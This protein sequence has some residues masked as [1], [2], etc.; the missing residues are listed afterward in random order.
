VGT[1]LHFFIEPGENAHQRY[2]NF[3]AAA[4][5]VFPQDLKGMEKH[6]VMVRDMVSGHVGQN[7]AHVRTEGAVIGIEAFGPKGTKLLDAVHKRLVY[8]HD[9]PWPLRAA[10]W[11]MRKIANGARRLTGRQPVQ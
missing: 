11:G 7:E 10:A 8:H 2:R 4:L 9:G 1:S 3:R 5:G 6:Q